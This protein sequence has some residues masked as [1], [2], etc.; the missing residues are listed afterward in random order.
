MVQGVAQGEVDNAVGEVAC[1]MERSRRSGEV[2][3]GEKQQGRS[4]SRGRSKE[5]SRGKI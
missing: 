5:H 2:M 1:L 4:R 3:F